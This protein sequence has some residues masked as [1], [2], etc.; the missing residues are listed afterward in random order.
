MNC[1]LEL[2]EEKLIV[3][4]IG[5]CCYDTWKDFRYSY[6]LEVDEQEVKTCE[7]NFARTTFIDSSGLGGLLSL[8]KKL[9][10]ENNIVLSNTNKTIYGVLDIANFAEF[11]TIK[12]SS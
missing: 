9:S 6:L 4:V 2:S 12:P 5:K 7:V 3:N 8:R 11:F 10:L 1:E